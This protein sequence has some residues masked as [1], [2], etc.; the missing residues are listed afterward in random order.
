MRRELVRA[1]FDFDRP[2][3]LVGWEA[4]KSYVLQP[5]PGKKTITVG[6]SCYHAADR[7]RTLWLEFPR[8]FEDTATG[9]GQKCGCGFSRPVPA[10][11]V[12]V[13]KANWWW[14]EHGTLGDWFREV[15]AT[16]EFIRCSALEDWRFEGYSL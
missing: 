16:P 3:L 15:E 14:A 2:Q 11:L 8:E 9:L 4:F 7:D 10:D 6:F 5:V 1:S 13:D 12:G